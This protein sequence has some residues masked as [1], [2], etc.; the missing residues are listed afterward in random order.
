[1]TK[2]NDIVIYEK[3]TSQQTS[4]ALSICSCVGIE[5]NQKIAGM[6]LDVSK[7]GWGKGKR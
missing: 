2:L 4:Y 3:P 5:R 1:M 7:K 6:T